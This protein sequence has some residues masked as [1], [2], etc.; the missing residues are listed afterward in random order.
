MLGVARPGTGPDG[1]RGPIA[2]SMTALTPAGPPPHFDADAVAR[3]FD[4]DT[5]VASQREAFANLSTGAAQLA[6]KI[7]LP[8]PTDGSVAFCYVSRLSPDTGVV[9]KFGAVHPGNVGLGLPTVHAVV[10][11]LDPATG[12]VAATFDGQSVTTL[13][14]AAGTTVAALELAG[15]GS[16]RPGPHTVAVLGGSGVQGRGH[17]RYLAHHLDVAGLRIWG[18]DADRARVAAAELAAGTGVPALAVGSVAEALAGADVVVTATLATEPLFALDE[19]AP[20]AVVLSVGSFDVGRCEVPRELLTAA[21]AVVVDDVATAAE[22]TGP[23]VDALGA[24]VV[25]R[26]ELVALGD[27]LTGKRVLPADV[28]R[29]VVFFSIGLGVQDAAAAVA[30]LRRASC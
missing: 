15:P 23:V 4:P 18:R 12:Q 16:A 26:D 28:A 10:T 8:H 1:G 14:T 24:G 20:G 5:G 3:Y 13:R 7:M 2:C 19:L 29:P 25:R 30:I 21:S 11:L 9:C 17:A 22:F 6:G 27:L